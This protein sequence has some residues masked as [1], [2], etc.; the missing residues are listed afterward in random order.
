[1]LGF[2]YTYM[3]GEIDLKKWLFA[4]LFGSALVL[5]ACGDD[6]DKDS[7]GDAPVEASA[8]EDA[9]KKSCAACHG[10][11]LNDGSAPDLSAIGSTYS[12]E[13]IADIIEN[14]KGAMQPQPVSEDD[15]TSISEW[16]ASKK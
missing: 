5:G 4:I 15:R 8:G 1:M 11:N 7:D 14:G 13:E 12:A 3:R 16:L 2:N 9:Y 10:G 6:S